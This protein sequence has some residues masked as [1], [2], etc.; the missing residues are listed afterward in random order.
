MEKKCAVPR[1]SCAGG[2]GGGKVVQY[3]ERVNSTRR[4]TFAV[5]RQGVLCWRRKSAVSR[6]SH[7]QCEKRMCAVQGWS[8]LQYEEKVVL[9]EEKVYSFRKVHLQ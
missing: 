6:M 2:G 8:H 9:C 4:V 1:E 7:R 3:E 5:G